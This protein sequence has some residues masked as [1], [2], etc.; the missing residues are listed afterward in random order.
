MNDVITKENI[1][2]KIYEI[3][4]KQVKLDSDLAILYHCSNGTKTLNQT[5]KRNI[6]RF[7]EDFYFQLNEYE[8]ANLKSQFGTSSWNNHGGIR[9]LPYAFTEQGVAMLASV[10]RTVVAAEVSVKIMRAFVLMRQ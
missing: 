9:K 4:G 1:Q 7:P 5:V 8:F 6:E 2:N 10:L 3:R